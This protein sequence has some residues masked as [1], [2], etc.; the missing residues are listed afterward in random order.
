MDRKTSK[1]T[2]AVLSCLFAALITIGA[3]IALPIPGSPVPIVLQNMF[4]MLAALVLGPWWGLAATI[5]YLCF[6]ILGMPVFSGGSSGIAALVGPTGGYLVGYLPAAIV[7]G[8]I[9]RKGGSRL[10]VNLLACLVGEIFV[11]AFGLLRLKAVLDASWTK[12][13]AAGLLPFIVVDI[14]KLIAASLLAPRLS[15]TVSRLIG[16]ESDA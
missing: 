6:G 8:A 3:F 13:I 11:Y 14:L 9:S 5:I 1:L 2:Y 4:I 10:W 16:A 7:I 15:E 12:T